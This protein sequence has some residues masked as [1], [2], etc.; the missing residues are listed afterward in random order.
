MIKRKKFKKKKYRLVNPTVNEVSLVNLACTGNEFFFI[1]NGDTVDKDISLAT[2][3]TLEGTALQ[4]GNYVL[5]IAKCMS[6]SSSID[7]NEP[8]WEEIDETKLPMSAFA[9][10]GD[11]EDRSTWK[12]PH[13]FV[14]NGVIGE[15]GLYESGE[16]FL[17][18]GKLLAL[19]NSFEKSKDTDKVVLS[20]ITKH[21][22]DL[23]LN[24]KEEADEA[25]VLVIKSFSKSVT[26][27]DVD[28][29]SASKMAKNLKSLVEY[30]ELL[31]FNAQKALEDLV[32]NAVT[33]HKMD[34]FDKGDKE[35]SEA[36]TDTTNGSDIRTAELAAELA[37]IKEMLEENKKILDAEKAEKE[38]A[39]KEAEIEAVVAKRVKEQLEKIKAEKEA[40][41]KKSDE[42]ENTS[43][44]KTNEDTK[45]KEDKEDEENQDEMVEVSPEELAE[46]ML[47]AQEGDN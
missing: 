33:V 41:E 37:S 4:F 44:E 20:E 27:V 13:H 42:D 40:K 28:K 24:R 15:S 47:E 19:S 17:H 10:V 39:E 9:E 3:S 38:K 32:T 22:K 25:D 12:Y 23:G 26:S 6:H 7:P 21:I 1:K 11:P 43:S 18:R 34:K 35:M 45:N 46:L 8:K 30:K 36:N 31:P 5:H 29:E 14:K 2:D 16:L